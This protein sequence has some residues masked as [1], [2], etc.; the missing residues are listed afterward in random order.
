[1]TLFRPCIDIHGGKVKQIVGGTLK[2]AG[3]GPVENFVSSYPPSYFADRY[4]ENQLTGGHVIL[5]GPGNEVAGR[6]ALAAYPGGLQIGGGITQENAADWLSAG[7]S[8][9][10]VTSW[11]FPENDLDFGRLATFD[12]EKLVVDLSCRKT[13]EGWSVAKDRWQSLTGFEITPQNLDRLTGKCAELLI[14]AADVEGKQGGVDED[15]VKLLGDWE[16]M[17]V[18]Y[19]GGAR[20][21]EDLKLVNALSDGSVDLTLGSA[22]DIFGGAGAT[23]QECVDWNQSLR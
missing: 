3:D 19:A 18:T 17:P 12:P 14:H 16:G 13:A 10:I 1:M 21:L 20:S 22:L 5:L 11:L 4:R 7:A 2:D 23:Y 15:L 6:E 9:V 8:H